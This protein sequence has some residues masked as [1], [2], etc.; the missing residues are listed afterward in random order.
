M[1]GFMA[2]IMQVSGEGRPG[3]SSRCE[4]AEKAKQGGWPGFFIEVTGWARVRVHTQK[5]F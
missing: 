5:G 2:S 3:L 4:M 1:K